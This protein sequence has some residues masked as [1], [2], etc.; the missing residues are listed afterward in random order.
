MLKVHDNRHEEHMKN[1]SDLHSYYSFWGSKWIKFWGFKVLGHQ[2]TGVFEVMFLGSNS[3][4]GFFLT[5][6]GWALDATAFK[7]WFLQHPMFLVILV[8][9]N[10]KKSDPLAKQKDTHSKLQNMCVY[11][12]IY[13]YYIY[14]ENHLDET[15]SS[16]KRRQ[17]QIDQAHE[18]HSDSVLSFLWPLRHFCLS[19]RV[20]WEFHQ[21]DGPSPKKSP[22]AHDLWKL[23]N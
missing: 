2:D 23:S 18:N 16:P 9:L 1:K 10:Q 3:G 7:G 5:Q 6:I 20:G 14:S 4:L 19:R 17:K 11:V 22:S 13:M 15:E 8:L 12:Y 21:G